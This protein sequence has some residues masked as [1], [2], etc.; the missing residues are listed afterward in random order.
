MFDSRT[1]VGSNIAISAS[2]FLALILYF[3][4]ETILSTAPRI[5]SGVGV[6]VLTFTPIPHHSVLAEVSGLASPAP[7]QTSGVPFLIPCWEAAYPPFVTKTALWGSSSSK[8]KKSA[9]RPLAGIR[10]PTGRAA[11]S[12][13]VQQPPKCSRGFQAPP[14]LGLR[15]QS[16]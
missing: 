9:T 4:F 7:A 8:G 10:V 11:P 2:K 12:C 16:S 5:A 1:L 15:D 6:P 14:W 13:Q 3:G